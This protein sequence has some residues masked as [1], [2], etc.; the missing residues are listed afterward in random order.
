MMLS[1]LGYLKKILLVSAV[2]WSWVGAIRAE[3]PTPPDQPVQAL[4]LHGSA[5]YQSNKKPF[6]HFDYVNPNAPKGGSIRMAASGT[7]DSLNPYVNKGTPVS[8]INLIYD[9]LMEQS[10]D[11]PFSLYPLVAES[12]IRAVDNSGIIFNINSKARFHDGTAITAEDVKYTFE[13]LTEKGHPFYRTY[14]SDVAQV[15]I[16]STTSVQFLFKHVNNPE[17]PFILSELP[18]LPKKYWESPDNDFTSGSLKIPL[19]SGPYEVSDVDNGRS[20]SFSRVNNYWAKDL[21][22]NKGRYN[23]D[24]IRYDY[25]RDENVALQSL[26]AKGYDFRLENSAK[27]WATAYDVPLVQQG[28]L[29]LEAIPTRNPAPIQG[30]AYN[31]RK[32]L[33]KDRNVRKALSYAMDFEW[34]NRNIFY[35]SYVRSKSYFNNSG[36]EATGVPTGKELELLEPF[37]KDLPPDLFTK[38]YTV[39][40]TDGS[41]N[42]RPQLNEALSLFEKAGWTLSQ[43]KLLNNKGER[44][45]IELLLTQASMERVALPFKK[46]L[47]SMGIDFSIR[48]VDMSQYIQRIRS[49]DYDMIV[50]G[51]GQST[52]PGNE[53]AGYWGSLAADT[54]GSRNYMG[55]K[56]H[57]VDAMI[58]KVTVADTREELT[59]AVRALDRVLLWGEYIIPQWYIPHQR[60]VYTNKL[61][62]PQSE[63]LYSIDLYSWWIDEPK[64][65]LAS[66]SKEG[67][68]KSKTTSGSISGSN[69]SN[70]SYIAGGTLFLLALFWFIRRR[71]QA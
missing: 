49:F 62:H 22:V 60:L 56:N 33:F 42:I 13:L 7:F 66:A 65:S 16:L 69:Q 14:Y 29:V 63:S 70:T 4:T 10:H 5:K 25:Y 51:Y 2:S 64:K 9:T 50:V 23:F 58:D 44:F 30:F 38:H 35:N 32:E 21:P 19:G 27:N 8:G 36:M 37:R 61:K 26:L 52:S 48:S 67:T 46:N 47:E 54:Q 6:T 57:V 43:G 55:I 17:L 68:V 41:G 24:Q 20:I 45:K 31:L 12:A 11:E 3:T 39:P 18:V 28:E 71:K 59:T 53:Q 34:L 1:N 15:N 40:E